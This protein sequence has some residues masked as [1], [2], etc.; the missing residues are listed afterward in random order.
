MKGFASR[1]KKARHYSGL[2]QMGVSKITGIQQSMISK[3]ETGACE[4]SLETLAEL[5]K[6][7]KVGTDWLLGLCYNDP[8]DI[9][10]NSSNDGSYTYYEIWN[11]TSERTSECTER[12]ITIE[13]AKEHLANA[14]CDWCRPA[15]T[16]RIYGVA[17]VPTED[18]SITKV[19]TM[20]Y[21]N[22]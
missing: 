17:L 20:V 2:T 14:H 1:I 19:E 21:E 10:E 15:G 18:G 7:Y 16:G 9:Y 11:T 6:L 22:K 5:S 13:T 4:P 8:T 3:Y 12:C